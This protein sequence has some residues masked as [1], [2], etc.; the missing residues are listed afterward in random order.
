MNTHDPEASSEI[1]ER[2]KDNFLN[3]FSLRFKSFWK[4]E[5]HECNMEQC[6]LSEESMLC[7]YKRIVYVIFISFLIQLESLLWFS[8]N[9]FVKNERIQIIISLFC[10]ETFKFI[11]NLSKWMYC[12]CFKACAPRGASAQSVA[13]F[14]ALE[15]LFDVCPSVLRP[16]VL[17]SRACRQLQDSVCFSWRLSIVC[18]AA[19]AVVPFWS[20]SRLL[21]HIFLS[22]ILI[23]CPWMCLCSR[24]PNSVGTALWQ[25]FFDCLFWYWR[26]P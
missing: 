16:P 7:L 10:P 24:F 15:T 5:I 9:N 21:Q 4:S 20:F 12:L 2:K 3:T 22:G 23:P 17:C 6:H 25:Q 26:L 18:A 8:K 11:Q 14:L 13:F 19:Q 1:S